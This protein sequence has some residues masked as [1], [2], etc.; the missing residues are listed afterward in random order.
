MIFFTQ[1]L[2]SRITYLRD[3]LEGL[4]KLPKQTGGNKSSKEA[5]LLLHS[6]S[7][8]ASSPRPYYSFFYH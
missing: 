8:S 1:L 6:S 3:H 7:S 5:A 4:M 2:P